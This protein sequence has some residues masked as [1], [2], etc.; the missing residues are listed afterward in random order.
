MALNSIAIRIA[1]FSFPWHPGWM[2]TPRTVTVAEAALKFRIQSLQASAVRRIGE[3][4]AETRHVKMVHTA[5]D[6]LVRSKGKAELSV[7]QILPLD[8]LQPPS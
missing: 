3:L 7:R 2:L 1:F 4:S 6:L 5:A 8:A